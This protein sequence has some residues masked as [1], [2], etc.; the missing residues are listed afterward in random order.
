VQ[1]AHKSFALKPKRCNS[2]RA[3]KTRDAWYMG[4]VTSLLCDTDT[5]NAVESIPPMLLSRNSLG[6]LIVDRG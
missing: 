3:D 5:N 4:F 2:E 6:D 1:L